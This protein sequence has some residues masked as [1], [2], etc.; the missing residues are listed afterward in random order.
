[1]LGSTDN[2]TG[3]N[4]P[5][6]DFVKWL[7]V[8]T[9]GESR[10]ILL[11]IETLLHITRPIPKTTESEMATEASIKDLTDAIRKL[12]QNM[13]ILVSEN[14]A[15]RKEIETLGKTIGRIITEDGSRPSQGTPDDDAELE[16]GA[17]APQSLPIPS[18]TMLA[19]ASQAVRTVRTLKGEDDAGVEDFIHA[20]KRALTRCSQPDILLELILAE[21]LEGH[22][23]RSIRHIQIENYDDLYTALRQHVAPPSSVNTCRVALD[24][25]LQRG[26]S[27]RSYNMEFRQKLNELRYAI[28]NK[29]AQPQ[30]RGIAL[31]EVEETAKHTYIK[32][33]VPDLAKILLAR[34]P[35]TLIE[36]QQA[37][38]EIEQWMGELNTKTSTSRF[39]RN[40]LPSRAP[41]RRPLASSP[42]QIRSSN[43]KQSTVPS[44]TVPLQQRLQLTCY[45]CGAKGHTQNQCF[46]K[47]FPNAQS[48]KIP[49]Q[50]NSISEEDETIQKNE[51]PEYQAYSEDFDTSPPS[52][53]ECKKEGNSC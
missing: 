16:D 24:K 38:Q 36:A 40:Q 13:E 51:N 34:D 37:A 28:Q 23:E 42:P 39:L 48:G 53:L 5:K 6:G 47:N 50:V 19:T 22:A 25:V 32:H 11:N 14:D 15:R 1:M 49:P 35:S 21:K 43:E 31:K 29:Y 45:K 2:Q 7:P 41:V 20:I 3:D 8:K 30:M 44:H 10:R 9:L 18:G 17:T 26:R 52:W 4:W 12:A 33:L 27:V 46:R